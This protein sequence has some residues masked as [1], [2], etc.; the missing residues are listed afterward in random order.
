[1]SYCLGL[2]ISVIIRI[3][4]SDSQNTAKLL[5]ETILPL[6]TGVVQG[7]VGRLII[8]D[9]TGLKDIAAIA[10]EAGAMLVKAENWGKGLKE[11]VQS[12]RSDWV[13]LIDCGVIIE[14][15][16]WPCLERHLRVSKAI[17][18]SQ[19]DWSYFKFWCRITSKIMMDQIVFMPRADIKNEVFGKRFG[20][21]LIS[22]ST[23]TTRLKL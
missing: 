19:P 18:L 3:V 4:C 22:L 7:L 15:T 10:E 11:A 1:M 2:M 8:V 9:T 12:L 14:P 23:R 6:V 5:A 21:D 17:C 20:K 16:I 13:L